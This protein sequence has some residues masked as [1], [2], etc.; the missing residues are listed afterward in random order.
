[1]YEWFIISGIVYKPMMII[2]QFATPH[3]PPP[4]YMKLF[5]KSSLH[6]VGRYNSLSDPFG[7]TA[8]NTKMHDNVIR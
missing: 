1:M 5:W 8:I 2:P 6:S 7:V 3:P 4:I